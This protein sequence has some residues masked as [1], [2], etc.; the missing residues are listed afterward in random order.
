MKKII[1]KDWNDWIKLNQDRGCDLDEMYGIL[2]KEGFDP[3]DIKNSLGHEIDIDLREKENNQILNP[4]TTVFKKIKK[5]YGEY[6]IVRNRLLKEKNLEPSHN[7]TYID[8][9]YQLKTS[10]AEIY[11]ID[12]FL[13]E[14]E[15]EE[16][17]AVIKTRLKPSTIA[18]SVGDI[19]NDKYFRTSK[20]CDLGNLESPVVAE[21]DRRICEF[22]GI[23]QKFSE[24][25]QGQFYEV[26]EEFKAHTDFF[27][28]DQ[29]KSFTKKRGQRTY[30]FMVYLNEVEEGG[31][32]EFININH[33]FIPKQGSAIS[34]N[35]LTK[36]GTG[37]HNTIHQAHPVTKGSKAIITKWFRQESNGEMFKKKSNSKIKSY[38][39]KGFKK[40]KLDNALFK[41]VLEFYFKNR[42]KEKN[43]HIEGDFVYI[44]ES[45]KEASKIIE[46]S[47]ELKE[48]IHLSLQKPLEDWTN[49]VLEPTFVYG[50]RVY[51]EGSLLVP[52]RDR[53]NTHIVSAIINVDQEVEEEWPLIIEDHFYRKHEVVLKPGEVIYYESATLLHGRPVPLNGKSFANIFCHFMPKDEL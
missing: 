14:K 49:L 16:L 34:W 17:I 19:E 11:S 22:I 28:K 41:E 7:T 30:T 48:K 36:E 25:I 4:K 12:D 6:K 40:T 31:E 45:R 52:H 29:M 5:L 44:P 8:Q 15:C 21:I 1:T 39:K 38:T 23:E 26:G 18:T 37:N 24:M 27:E 51:Q 53:E 2:L 3:L 32:T 42:S 47:K 43:E 10:L 50:I 13:N 46:L 33:T 20:T 35:N 9:S